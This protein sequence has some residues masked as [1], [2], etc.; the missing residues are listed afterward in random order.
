MAPSAW[1]SDRSELSRAVRRAEKFASNR[2][3][4]ITDVASRL[5]YPLVCHILP[6][7]RIAS[8]P[9]EDWLAVHGGE[10]GSLIPPQFANLY[11]RFAAHTV[12][13][14]SNPRA[15]WTD[16]DVWLTWFRAGGAELR[17]RPSKAGVGVVQ[18]MD[19]V[20]PA[21][22][23]IA[24]SVQ[25]LAPPIFVSVRFSGTLENLR[26]EPP[27]HDPDSRM[28]GSVPEYGAT[29][30]PLVVHDA[31]EFEAGWPAHAQVLLNQ[32]AQ[33]CGFPSFDRARWRELARY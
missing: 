24:C 20:I 13:F 3:A 19:H 4:R 22:G 15:G 8:Y 17:Q 9:P 25:S 1:N 33:A 27:A 2:S 31:R 29:L 26:L 10:A 11:T 21:L 12:E 5:Y 7:G 6:L 16:Y 18:M 28:I 32:F 14:V 23:R 30:P